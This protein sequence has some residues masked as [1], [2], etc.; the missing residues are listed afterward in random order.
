[1]L[2]KNTKTQDFQE[3]EKIFSLKIRFWLFLYKKKVEQ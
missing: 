3:M 2:Q 1:M